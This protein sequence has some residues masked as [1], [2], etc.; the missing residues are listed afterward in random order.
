[1]RP[2][3]KARPIAEH[4][5]RQRSA[6]DPAPVLAPKRLCQR[7]RPPP[8]RALWENATPITT[9]YSRWIYRPAHTAPQ[10]HCVTAHPARA[11]DM[12]SIEWCT[13]VPKSTHPARKGTD[14]T[15]VIRVSHQGVIHRN[16]WITLWM[17][18]NRP[19]STCSWWRAAKCGTPSAEQMVRRGTQALALP[20]N[21]PHGTVSLPKRQRR[22]STLR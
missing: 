3:V 17:S 20:H 6:Q 12:P 19:A 22:R 5:V 8:C 18:A 21:R 7:P 11:W 4:A 9:R 10:R 13:G 1:M 14:I 2:T 15:L 16:R